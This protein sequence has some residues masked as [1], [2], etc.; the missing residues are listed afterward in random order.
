MKTE[1]EYK[2]LNYKEKL[3]LNFVEYSMIFRFYEWLNKKK[4]ENK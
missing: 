1:K 2:K 3:K 4:N